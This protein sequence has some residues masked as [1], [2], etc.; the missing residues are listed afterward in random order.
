[1]QGIK[2]HQHSLTQFQVQRGKRFVQQKHLR[3]VHKGT[4][5]RDA[6]FLT[7]AEF[8]RF[9]V[10]VFGHLDHVEVFLH[11]LSDVFFLRLCNFQGERDIVPYGHVR[12]ERIALK[13]RMNAAF[14][15][16][17]AGNIHTVQ[18]NAPLVRFFEAA[19]DS[20]QGA[21]PASAGTEHGKNLACID[22]EGYIVED[23]L[24]AEAFTDIFDSKDFRHKCLLV[25]LMGT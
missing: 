14:V 18:D 25:I 7:A 16:R 22:G 6:L 24:G 15:R 4:G 8:A 17:N 23:F 10:G 5:D 1:M 20:Q 3:A 2:F 11:L 21:F 12:E 13:H 19:A 9:F